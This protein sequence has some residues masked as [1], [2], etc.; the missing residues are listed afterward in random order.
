MNETVSDESSVVCAVGEA[1]VSP[2]VT[3]ATNPSV[4]V[5]SMKNK[6]TEMIRREDVMRCGA[7]SSSRTSEVWGQN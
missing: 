6:V 2:I 3:T 4:S 5:K 7:I 1:I